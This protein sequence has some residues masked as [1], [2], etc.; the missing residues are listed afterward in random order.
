MLAAKDS[1]LRI[2]NNAR[3]IILLHEV[4]LSTFSINHDFPDVGLHTPGKVSLYHD[5]LVGE[6][7][8]AIMQVTESSKDPVK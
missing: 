1:L 3:S 5:D 8:A 6:I 7:G 2:G 4:P